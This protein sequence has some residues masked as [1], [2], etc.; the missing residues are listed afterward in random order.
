MNLFSEPKDEQMLYP[1]PPK[2]ISTKDFLY[3]KDMMSWNL[4]AAKKM[5]WASQ[6]CQLPDLKKEFEAA[7]QMHVNHYDELLKT[8]QQSEGGPVS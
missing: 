8:L 2:M 6:N 4:S 7:E 5:N 1:E 3:Y